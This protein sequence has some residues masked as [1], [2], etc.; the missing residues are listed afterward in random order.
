MVGGP[1][2]SRTVA[3][4]PAFNEEAA[5]PSLL[6]ELRSVAGLVP[7]VVDDGSTDS[8]AQ[9][10]RQAGVAVLQLPFNLGVG[11]AVRAGLCWAV[12]RDAERV[13]V[14]DADGQH[15]P[16]DIDAL[17]TAV[18]QGA[19]L[20]IGSRFAE[21]AGAYTVGSTRRRAM[22]LLNGI[23]RSTTG[24]AVTDAT[25]GFRAMN[26]TV[27]EFLAREYP[28]EYLADTVEVV[29]MVHRAGFD[30]V[31]VPVSMR[32]RAG[33]LPSSRRFRLA[34]NMLRLLVGI[35]GGVLFGRGRR[36]T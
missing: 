31:E 29:V 20:A 24:V 26:R 17:I 9:V 21:G 13:L 8:T 1:V 25:S 7:V 14:I 16:S 11:G 4:I 22:R 27:A 30:V 33:G 5:L 28:V 35:L 36:K 32:I 10:A 19:G 18:D 34:F 12:E 15:N 3:V 2:V 23:V 6:N